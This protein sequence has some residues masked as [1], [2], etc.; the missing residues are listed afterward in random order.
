MKPRSS[1]AP[2]LALFLSLLPIPAAFGSSKVVDAGAQ[3]G[4]VERLSSAEPSERAEAACRIGQRPS[5]GS[6]AVPAL[7]KLLGDDLQIGPVEC[8]LS[9]WLKKLL[10]A[11]PEEWRKFETSPGREAAKAL[12]RI[13]RPA[14]DPLVLALRAPQAPA[15]AN[16]A[17]GLGEMSPG[18][19][20]ARGLAVARLID[21]L[22]DEDEGVR[23][24]STRALGKMDSSDAVVPLLG[25]LRD[26]SARVRSEAAWALGEI[27][28][29]RAVEPLMRTL[30]D[31]DARVRGRAAWA[32]GELED[33]RAVEGL[34]LALKDADGDVRSQVAWALGELEDARAVPLLVRALQDK[35]ARVR[36]QAAWA[37]GE[38][39]DP[40][41]VEG[42]AAA[43]TDSDAKVKSQAAWALGEIEDPRAVPGLVGALRDADAHVRSQAAWALGEIQDAKAVEGLAGALKD[44]DA[45]VRKQAAWA[46]GEIR[47]PRASGPLASALKDASAE[48][49][50]QAAWALGRDEGVRMPSSDE[51]LR[52]LSR[53]ERQIMDFLYQQRAR[54]APPRCRPACPT[55]RAI[56]RC[57]RCCACSRTRAT[58]ATSRTARATSTCR[59]SRATGRSASALRHVVRTFFDG[60]PEQV[61]AALLDDRSTQL[62]DDELDR[63]AGLIE[64]ARKEGA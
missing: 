42:L 16:A 22:R 36:S 1:V 58:C 52:E 63:L 35:E 9:P 51:P 55:L 7:A 49:R 46:L 40:A 44:T 45:H 28:D 39:E 61:V 54:H 29:P 10:E 24:E 12:A 59:A 25:T 64:R 50:K 30:R 21:A 37:L 47:D 2:S 19:S 48:V 57:A 3:R 23:V 6:A 27:D 17:L 4:L 43:L 13:G 20:S 33:K 53:R 26:N 60:S 31:D 38:I 11:K 14:L 8:G 34:M 56:P 62:S 32:L 18:D 41:A 5:E 15:R